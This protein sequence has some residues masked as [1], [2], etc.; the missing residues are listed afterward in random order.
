MEK[1]VKIAGRV[2][3]VPKEYYIHGREYK[4]LDTVRY[5]GGVYVAKKDNVNQDPTVDGD[6]EFWM[7][8]VGT[9]SVDLATSEK[10]GIS[11]PDGKTITIDDDGVLT[12]K[13]PKPDEET[14]IS[15]DGTWSAVIPNPPKADGTTI[16]DNDGT[17][18]AVIP[19]PPAPPIPDGVTIVDEDGIW[20]AVIPDPPEVPGADGETIV[21]NEE[22]ELSA[23]VAT[24]DKP[25]IVKPDGKTI[26][27]DENG[28]IV[29]A[30][31]GFVGSTEAAK[32]A[33]EAGEF[34]DGQL[35]FIDDDFIPGG[36]GGG[37]TD[38]PEVYVGDSEPKD[39]ELLWVDTREEV[40]DYSAWEPT[41]VTFTVI[42]PKQ[43][44]GV[45]DDGQRFTSLPTKNNMDTDNYDYI[46]PEHISASAMWTKT[47]CILVDAYTTQENGGNV[48]FIKGITEM[49]D[50]LGVGI[51]T[52][53]FRRKKM[54]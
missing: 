34:T 3:M 45:I 8:M 35:V 43:D 49:I 33:M 1:E 29:G 40:E 46:M 13:L 11:K 41:I 38:N 51:Q 2:A 27:I 28:T 16:V 9:A 17:W 5:L 6:N 23:V 54:V 44:G 50:D 32:A 47:L 36:G 10:P 15:E 48:Y 30:S 53:A 20:S 4:R 18:S 21:Y 22:G 26:T 7:F 37:G 12:A 52:V 42:V 39:G 24:E 19:D 31:S 25:G 14:I